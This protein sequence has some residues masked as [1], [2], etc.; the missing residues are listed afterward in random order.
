[1]M[2]RRLTLA[3]V[4]A[5]LALTAAACV[6][7]G[8]A[9]YANGRFP[10][11]V[12]TAVTPQCRIVNELATPLRNLIAA[13]NADGVALEPEE[14]SYPLL[15]FQPQPPAIESCYRS[16]AGQVWWRNYYCSI[17]Q[18]GLAAVP[19]TS[20]HGLGRAVDFQDQLGELTF[21]SPGYAWLTAHAA[22]YGF[23]HPAWAAQGQPDAE[24][25]HWEG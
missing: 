17:G 20:R 4:V 25:W 8:G 22:Q 11:S 18:C 24:P 7:V 2:R 13:A 21:T 9:L 5:V 14:S 3:A 10:D 19:G 1:M 6:R 16:Y 12:L 23:S 15:F